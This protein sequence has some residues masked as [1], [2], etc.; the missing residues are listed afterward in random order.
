[1]A[2][3]FGPGTTPAD[4]GSSLIAPRSSMRGVCERTPE[5]P[6]AT[7][8]EVWAHIGICGATSA[9]IHDPD[10]PPCVCTL[11]PGHD[12][13][14]HEHGRSVMWEHLDDRRKP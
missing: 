1:M 11:P 6:G 5:R 14:H 10:H 13:M 4:N 9:D 7:A 8:A 3:N 2:E 12:G